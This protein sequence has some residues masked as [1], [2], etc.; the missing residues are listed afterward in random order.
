MASVLNKE[1]V[2][3]ATHYGIKI[4]AHILR[5]EY[6]EDATLISVK[7]R[8]CGLV[9]NPFQ[10]GNCSLKIWIEK[11]EP[12]I[13]LSPEIARHHDLSGNIPDGDAIDFAALYYNQ[14]GQ[15]LLETLNREMWL[16][17]GVTN[18]QYANAP[19][20]P[21]GRGPRVSYFKAPIS[22]TRP[23][24]SMTVG[25]IYQIIT[26]NNA[27]TQTETL[28]EY[29]KTDK[30]RARLYKAVNFDYA[31]FCGE[32]SSRHNDRCIKTSGLL[33]LDFDHVEGLEGLFE[34][35]I[36]DPYF[37]TALLFRSPSGDGLK[38]IIEA[39]PIKLSRT[40][41]FKA[42]ASYVRKTYSVEVDSSGKDL[43]RA[44]FIPYDPNAYINPN[45]Q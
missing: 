36:E 45:Y 10:D 42:I 29:L 6:P 18:Y 9:R 24:M 30:K 32:F 17:I 43:A 3:S 37:E 1:A 7:G 40:E 34:R 25:E 33:C 4:Y 5:K 44:C 41:Y 39:E 15:Q 31:T 20:R 23:F 22:N 16:N 2:I 11:T 26:S 8:D 19:A 27:R 14:Q 35:L 21:I 38:W 28:R 13:T 12:S